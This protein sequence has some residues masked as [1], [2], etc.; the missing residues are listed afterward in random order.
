MSLPPFANAKRVLQAWTAYCVS[1]PNAAAQ[2]RAACGASTAAGGWAALLRILTSDSDDVRRRA[3]TFE[4]LKNVFRR[5]SRGLVESAFASEHRCELRNDIFKI[6]L[7]AGSKVE[8][9]RNPAPRQQPL[10]E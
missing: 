8:L 6:C 5:D 7:G 1:Q 10:G 4:A 2:R 9:H 3:G